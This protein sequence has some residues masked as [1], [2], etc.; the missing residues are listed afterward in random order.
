MQL[1]LFF[2][3]MLKRMMGDLHYLGLSMGT[4]GRRF[5]HVLQ[6]HVFFAISTF[7]SSIVFDRF[8]CCH[9]LTLSKLIVM[10]M[11]TSRVRFVR[12]PIERRII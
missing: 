2:C 8:F 1:D 7:S 10:S 11:R 3:Q 4:V 12:I 5:R 6:Q 9:G